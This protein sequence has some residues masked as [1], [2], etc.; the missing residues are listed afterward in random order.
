MQVRSGIAAHRRERTIVDSVATDD[1]VGGAKNIDA[2]AVLARSA[3]SVRDIVDLVI[4]HDGAV[5]A[6]C[7]PPYLDAVVASQTNPV[8]RNDKPATIEHVNGGIG[9]V[10]EHGLYHFAAGLDA[11]ERVLPGARELAV[12]D[13]DRLTAFQLHEP[14]PLWQS[15]TSAVEGEP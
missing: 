7:R 10:V 4:D 2:I 6:A 9:S 14:P 13:L 3:G 1:D 11:D 15:P 5:V 12:R 8:A